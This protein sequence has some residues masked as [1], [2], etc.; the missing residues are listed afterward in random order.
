MEAEKQSKKKR[1][2]KMKGRNSVVNRVQLDAK[3]DQQQAASERDLEAS[4]DHLNY[5]HEDSSSESGE[6]EE[7]DL[8]VPIRRAGRRWIRSTQGPPKEDR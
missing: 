4:T 8:A 1:A 7:E 5:E 2:N 6:G 3:V